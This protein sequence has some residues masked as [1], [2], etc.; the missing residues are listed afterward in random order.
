MYSSK[1]R[2]RADVVDQG[3][4]ARVDEPRLAP[5]LSGRRERLE[6]RTLAPVRVDE[7]GRR[8]GVMVISVAAISSPASSATR[9]WSTL[10]PATSSRVGG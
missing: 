4:L 1:P 7:P 10:R 6:D 8:F 9:G 3:A 2:G 5:L